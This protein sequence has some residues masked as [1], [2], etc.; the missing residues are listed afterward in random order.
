MNKNIDPLIQMAALKALSGPGKFPLFQ[1]LNAQNQQDMVAA[2]TAIMSTDIM[3]Q[4]VML[5]AN[6]GVPAN[7]APQV[8][9][10]VQLNDQVESIKDE[11][12]LFTNK[13]VGQSESRV[14]DHITDKFD[15][16]TASLKP[17]PRKAATPK[18]P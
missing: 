3:G 6:N 4:P 7:V 1:L 8:D 9:S 10:Q 18:K 5:P 16:L 14:R 17:K 15:E 11:L 13:A 2:G 12:R